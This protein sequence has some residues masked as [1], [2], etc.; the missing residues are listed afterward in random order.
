ML[1]PGEVPLFHAD[2]RVH[3]AARERNGRMDALG[4]K[5]RWAGCECKGMT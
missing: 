2:E 4:F 1:F 5:R 3:V